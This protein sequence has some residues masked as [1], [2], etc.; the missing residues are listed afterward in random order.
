MLRGRLLLLLFRFRR[1]FLLLRLLFLRRLRRFRFLLT[2]RLLRFLRLRLFLFTPLRRR[3]LFIVIQRRLYLTVI[4][5]PSLTTLYFFMYRNFRY[6]PYLRTTL[7]LLANFTVTFLL[8]G[9]QRP[10]LPTLA[11]PFRSL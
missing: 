11:L 10:F 7:H 1:R 2:L 5:L 6:L 4:L 8:M 3:G 9:N